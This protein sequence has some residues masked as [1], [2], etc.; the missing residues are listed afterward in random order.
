[1]DQATFRVTLTCVVPGSI[2]VGTFSA[3]AAAAS[4]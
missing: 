1:M 2:G 3:G 4:A